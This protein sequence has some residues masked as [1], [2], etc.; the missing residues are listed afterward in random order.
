MA[1]SF[2][3]HSTFDHLISD[4]WKDSGENG[5]RKLENRAKPTKTK[6]EKKKEREKKRKA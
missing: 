5:K 4:L 6:N 1:W 3:Q 2:V